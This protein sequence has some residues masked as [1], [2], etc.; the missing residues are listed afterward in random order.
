MAKLRTIIIDDEKPA[1]E[2]LSGMLE[3]ISDI[4]VIAEAE[5]GEEALEIIMELKP[6][7]LFLDIQMPLCSGMEVAA[8]LPDER[9]A[10]IFCT[11][12][13]QYAIDAFETNSVDYLLKPV[14]VQRLENAVARV[15][16]A[17][18]EACSRMGH[19]SDNLT[20]PTR[21]LGRRADKYIVIPQQGVLYFS[22]EGGLTKVH[23]REG[24]FWM[25]PSLA[26]L[27]NRLGK[28]GFYSVSR[29]HL[30]NLDHV[31]EIVP[32][33]AGD[34]GKARMADGKFLKV[35][36]RKMKDLLDRLEFD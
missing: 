15:V 9:P 26:E 11:A 27:E 25:E 29:Q 2:R 7:L 13:D 10:I 21:F 24:F 18:R 16:K 1:R 3:G 20:V 31:V 12:W 28:A 6:D 36:R 23:T 35:S 30:V 33:A 5:D 8:S 4:A 34:N 17:D 19:A 22:S 14:T 32:G